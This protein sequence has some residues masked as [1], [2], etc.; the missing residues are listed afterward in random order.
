[1][2]K[3]TGV[4]ISEAVAK[5]LVCHT[6]E[7]ITTKRRRCMIEL[8]LEMWSEPSCVYDLQSVHAKLCA[9][10]KNAGI[11]RQS[12]I[13]RVDATIR[14]YPKSAEVPKLMKL[15][16]YPTYKKVLDKQSSSTYCDEE[17]A[18]R[19]S[20]FGRCIKP[21]YDDNLAVFWLVENQIRVHL[22]LSVVSDL[23]PKGVFDE[24]R[25]TEF[26]DVFSEC[27]L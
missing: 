19:L 12:S 17:V 14:Q 20:A 10:G 23:R 6:K 1:M 3:P 25:E 11:Y 21:F 2:K 9:G 26:M 4:Q 8:A 15:Y 18:W 27:Y 24:F 16:F 22:G 5:F 7:E 13:L